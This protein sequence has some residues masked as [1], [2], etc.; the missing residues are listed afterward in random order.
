MTRNN[1]TAFL[2]TATAFAALLLLPG[3]LP[4]TTIIVATEILYFSLFAVSFNMLFGYGGLLPFGHGARND[5]CL[6]GNIS[7]MPPFSKGFIQGDRTP[8]SIRI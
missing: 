5:S 3:F 8:I 4:E 6:F 2:G 7:S 1:T